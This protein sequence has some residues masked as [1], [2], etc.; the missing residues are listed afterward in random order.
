MKRK[1]KKL[2]IQ[3]KIIIFTTI[4]GV[5]GIEMIW[6]LLDIIPLQ[7]IHIPIIILF[8]HRLIKSFNDLERMVELI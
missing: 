3:S 5:L 2:F 1:I 7:I 4:V 8:I 6:S